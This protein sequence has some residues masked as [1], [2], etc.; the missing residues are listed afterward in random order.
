M[1]LVL[2]QD[3]TPEEDQAQKDLQ[4]AKASALKAV[5]DARKV[6]SQLSIEEN[7]HKAEAKARVEESENAWQK[8]LWIALGAGM[9]AMVVRAWLRR[10][11]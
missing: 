5:D 9:V 3:T 11:G 6:Q 4:A 1:Q 8:W 7:I 2:V 10:R